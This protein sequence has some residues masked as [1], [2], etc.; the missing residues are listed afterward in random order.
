MKISSSLTPFGA[1]Y[2][3][4]L[5]LSFSCG[6]VIA[7]SG[8]AQDQESEQNTCQVLV[9]GQCVDLTGRWYI[10][11]GKEEA[12]NTLDI[13][14]TQ[15]QTTLT[16]TLE[17]SR[18]GSTTYINGT[19]KLK[20][21]IGFYSGRNPAYL[22]RQCNLVL[23]PVASHKIRVI[24]FGVCVQGAGAYPDGDYSKKLAE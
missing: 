4:F 16:F 13:R 5:A 18:G 14:L 10:Y 24:S 22:N 15:D 12:P 2:V 6:S 19:F 21:D 23:I 20:G 7:S 1:L 8:K 3:F 11:Q 17:A 9:A